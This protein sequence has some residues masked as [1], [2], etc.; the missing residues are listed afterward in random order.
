M[1]TMLPLRISYVKQKFKASCQVMKLDHVF[2]DTHVLFVFVR[3]FFYIWKP[4]MNI[5]LVS[6]AV[7]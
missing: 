5:T 7:T 4:F 3:F 1:L 2:V 6:R